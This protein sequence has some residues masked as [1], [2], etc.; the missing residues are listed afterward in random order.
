VS[1]SDGVYKANDFDAWIAAEFAER[2]VFTALVVL[3]GIDGPRVAPLCS[4][5]FS[6]IG[7]E[8]GWAEL[9]VLLAGSGMDWQGAAFFPVRSL[10][11]YPLDNPTARLRLRELEARIEADRLVLNEGHFFD[12]WGRRLMIEEIASQ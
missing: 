2:G 11:G 9:T 12:K 4:T 3:V 8:T 10:G 5:Y 6:V 1:I 7:D